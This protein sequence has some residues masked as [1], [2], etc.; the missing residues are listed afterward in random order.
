MDVRVEDTVYTTIFAFCRQITRNF[1]QHSA[2]RASVGSS[3][4]RRVCEERISPY[5]ESITCQIGLR[6]F[7]TDICEYGHV[8][9]LENLLY[10]GPLARITDFGLGQVVKCFI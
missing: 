10:R 6:K 7:S 2:F 1:F 3:D 4:A 9:L 5:P 8:I